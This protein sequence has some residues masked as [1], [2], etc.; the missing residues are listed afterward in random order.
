MKHLIQPTCM[1]ILLMALT[2]TALSAR[3]QPAPRW[4]PPLPPAVADHH[5]HIQ[6][7]RLTR[8]IGD[9]D[10]QYP[11]EFSDLSPE[12]L[13]ERTGTMA[14]ADLNQANVEYGVL[15][16]EAYMFASP[17]M[18]FKLTRRQVVSYTREE[19]EFNVD[20]ARASGGR[21]VAFVGV[22]PLASN[23]IPE[24]RY[25]AAAGGA[26][27]VKLHLANSA[28]NPQSPLD[29]MKLAHFVDVARQLNMP[30]IV[31]V[32][33]AKHYTASDAQVFISQVLPYAGDLPIQ[34]AHAG[35]WGGLD[36]QTLAAL[37]EYATAIR[38]HKEGTKNLFF[39]LALVVMHRTTDPKL[40]ARLVKLMR[41]IGMSR[42]V[43]GSDWP[44]MYSTR[45]Y[46]S[47]L[48]SELPLKRH[49]WNVVL[50][51]RAPW[52]RRGYDRSSHRL[53]T[54]SPPTSTE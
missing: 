36:D 12:F 13:K 38:D 39:D 37:S 33:N 18:H 47:L 41:E 3:L 29:V 16:S 50:Q 7:P 34:I 28:F 46:Y 10:H 30:I 48:E 26:D 23:A 15:L 32:R 40:L 54:G 51:N 2:G 45:E 42:F 53:V 19:N 9:T 17:I 20:A 31:H 4:N 11:K 8:L 52:L 5:M 35:G 14:L 1:W 21:L 27:G 49:E 43:M 24:L 25:W 22:D 44:A 6:G